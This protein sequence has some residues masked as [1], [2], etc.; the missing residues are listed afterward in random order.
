MMGVRIED[1]GQVEGMQTV[2]DGLGLLPLVTV[3]QDTKVVCQSHFRFKNYESDC[4]GYQIHMGT[5]STLTRGRA[6]NNAQYPCRRYNR[7]LPVE[8]RLLREVICT[9]SLTIRLF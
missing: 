3:M 1:P 5:T 9:V 2:T 6:A 4:A 8:R 7:R